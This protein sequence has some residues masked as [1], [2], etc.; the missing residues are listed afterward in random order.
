MISCFNRQFR[1]NE[2]YLENG[3]LHFNCTPFINLETFDQYKYQLL[4]RW[5]LAQPIGTTTTYPNLQ[6]LPDGFEK[7]IA[8]GDGKRKIKKQNAKPTPKPAVKR[9]EELKRK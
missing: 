7:F 1:A 5:S 3:T 4:V 2:V 6:K 8:L 9:L